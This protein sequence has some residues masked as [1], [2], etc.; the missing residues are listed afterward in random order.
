[1][2]PDPGT[3]P[4][5]RRIFQDYVAGN[6]LFAI[7]EALTNDNVPCPSASDPERNRHRS[8]IAWSKSAIRVILTNPRYTGRQVWNKQRTDEVLVDV[9][10][11]SLGYTSIMRWNPTERWVSSKELSH[12]PLIDDDTFAQA[13]SL[14]HRRGAKGDTHLNHRTRHPYVFRGRVH[15]AVCGR[16]MQGQHSRNVAYYRCR[17]AKEY[18]IANKVNHPMDVFLREDAL[19]DPI[20]SWLASAFAPTHL[21][22]TIAALTDSQPAN[23]NDLRREQARQ[24]IAA[25]DAKL[26]RYRATLDAGADIA[27]VTG[28]ITETETERRRTQAELATITDNQPAHL[29]NADIAA[30]SSGLGDVRSVLANADPHDKAEVYRQLNLR[31]SYQPDNETVHAMIDLGA[32]RGNLVRVRSRHQPMPNATSR[33]P[34]LFHCLGD[35]STPPGWI[36]PGGLGARLDAVAT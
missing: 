20:D 12:E 10:D 34:R 26:H 11:V 25:C 2:T 31:L 24:R 32:H 22:R 9:R 19:I 4:V 28:W 30:L 17:Y 8:G 5:V 7:A 35:C 36:C 33:C 29:S 1:M 18:A 15:C 13:Q 21:A 16:R 23:Y 14:M 6:G 3:A 27:V